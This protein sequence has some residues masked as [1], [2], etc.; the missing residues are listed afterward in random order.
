MRPYLRVLFA[1]SLS[2]LAVWA[3]VQNAASAEGN[4]GAGESPLQPSALDSADQN[5]P[6]TLNGRLNYAE[7]LLEATDGDCRQRADAAQRQLDLVVAKP[8]FLVVMPL[9]AAQ[10]AD[11]EYGVHSTRAACAAEP[12]VRESELRAAHD[13]ALRAADL[14]RDGT[15]YQSTAVMQFNAAIADRELGDKASAARL[16]QSAIETDEA[17]GFQADRESNQALL[18]QW[19]GGGSGPNREAQPTNLASN[20]STALKF[21]WSA[22]DADVAVAA[23]YVSVVDDKIVRSQGAATRVMTIRDGNPGWVVSFPTNVRTFNFDGWPQG[24]GQSHE[25]TTLLLANIRL[26]SPDLKVDGAGDFKSVVDPKE[27]STELAAETTKLVRYIFP[28]SNGSLASMHDVGRVVKY[29]SAPDEIKTM[30]AEDYDLTTAAWINAKLDQ[31]IWYDMTA[32]M[33][34]PGTAYVIDHDIHF[35]YTHAM[36]CTTA[37]TTPSCV[38]IVLYATPNLDA[39]GK[40]GRFMIANLREPAWI[41]AHYWSETDIRIVTDPDNLFPYQSDVRRYSYFS[42]H[43]GQKVVP[44]IDSERIVSMWSYR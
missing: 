16:L 33:R 21:S 6:E 35:S 27:V 17:Y 29:L 9:G 44:V 13:A 24:R 38:E 14:Y 18:R 1:G 42:A 2:G 19:T 5:S 36:P 25:L 32:P 43:D 26:K 28:N 4:T 34:L 3:A 10:A 23:S 40:W 8:A 15:D 20:R 31:G 7:H 39:L 11:I 30:V 12:S 22:R 37:S 41:I